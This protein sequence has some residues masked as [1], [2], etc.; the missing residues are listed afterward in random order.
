MWMRNDEEN[1]WDMLRFCLCFLRYLTL[2]Q[3][4]KQLELV[5][6]TETLDGGQ[7][8]LEYLWSSEAA[9]KWKISQRRVQIL[10]AED[11]IPGVFKLG[12]NWAIPSDV[13]KPIDKRKKVV[14]NNETI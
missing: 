2:C 9:K 8:Q 10:C 6:L 13:E 12:E 4:L 5:R 14:T 11:R 3:Y 1:N 7:W